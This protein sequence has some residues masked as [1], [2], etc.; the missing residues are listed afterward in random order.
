MQVVYESDPKTGT[1]SLAAFV[2][3][4]PLLY[5]QL[6][7][8]LTRLSADIETF[9]RPRPHVWLVNDEHE[10]LLDGAL[11]MHP[12]PVQFTLMPHETLHRL[13]EQIIGDDVECPGVIGDSLVLEPLAQS[14]TRSL[15]SLK[16]CH[17][18]V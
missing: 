1:K 13:G 18:A 10:A 8:I 12:H 15:G 11:R 17:R 4:E 5:G 9:G 16:C 7:G 6:L 3:Q 14:M 2:R